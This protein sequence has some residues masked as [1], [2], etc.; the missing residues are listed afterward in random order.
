[1]LVLT[2]SQTYEAVT[3]HKY[4]DI[5]KNNFEMGG[6]EIENVNG[7]ERFKNNVDTVYLTFT[8]KAKPSLMREFICR[9]EYLTNYG[10]NF[11]KFAQ[12]KYMCPVPVS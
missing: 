3:V 12:S 7:N 10:E 5:Q 9:F 2:I 6:G 4:E 8:A 1:M 11:V